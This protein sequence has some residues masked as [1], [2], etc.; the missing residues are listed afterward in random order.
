MQQLAAVSVIRAEADAPVRAATPTPTTSS[1]LAI[2]LVRA[3]FAK[4]PLTDM[5]NDPGGLP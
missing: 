5:A 3:I 4:L 1:S 2:K